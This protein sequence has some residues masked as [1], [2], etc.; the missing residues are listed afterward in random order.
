MLLPE[1]IIYLFGVPYFP[2][3]TLSHFANKPIFTFSR[4][5]FQVFKGKS[6]KGNELCRQLQFY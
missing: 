2:N 5:V 6:N 1:C 3:I 4:Y